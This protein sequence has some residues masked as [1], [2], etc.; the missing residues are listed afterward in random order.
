MG[1]RQVSSKDGQRFAERIKA[2]WI[3]ASAFCNEH[4]GA[5]CP[6]MYRYL[7]LPSN[8]PLIEDVFTLCLAEIEKRSIQPIMMQRTSEL[9][10]PESL[11]G[12][13]LEAVKS[14]FP[15]CR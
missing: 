4:V 11:V 5:S 10:E 9:G 8:L 2:A 6:F 1:S 13:Q 12:V 7:Y 3:E 15:R 14:S